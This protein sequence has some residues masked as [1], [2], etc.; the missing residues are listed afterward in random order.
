MRFGFI[1]LLIFLLGGCTVP[2]PSEPAVQITS[3]QNQWR[4]KDIRSYRIAVM[5]VQAI[6]HAQT[7]TVTVRDGA[8]TEQSAVCTPAPFEGHECKVQAFDANEFTVNG[9]FQTALALAPE[10]AKYQLRVTFDEQ[11]HF[12]KTISSDQKEVV[13]DETFW[14]VVSFEALP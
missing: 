3:A 2:G 1:L 14:R 6:W 7:N 13:D 10:S 11:Y 8:V 9:L 4:A 12:P 5:K